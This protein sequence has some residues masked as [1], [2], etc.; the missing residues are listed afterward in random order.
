MATGRINKR[1]VDAIALPPVGKRAHLWDDELR[2]FGCMVTDKG[3]K[4]YLVQYRLGGRGAKTRRVTIGK[5]GSPWTPDTART[6]AREL[7][8]QIWR[9]VD[10]FEAG[11]EALQAAKAEKDA[12]ARADAVLAKLAFGAVADDYITKAKKKLRR[13]SE[14]E[15]IINRDLRP[16]FG[17]TPLPSLTAET[18]NDQ[19]AAIAE[20]S[21]SAALKAYV[22][23]RAIIAFAHEKHRKLYPLSASPLPEVVRPEAGGQRERHLDDNEVRLFWEASRVL[24]WPFGPIYNPAPDRHAAA[25]DRGRRMVGDKNG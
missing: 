1:A 24:G 3:A 9:K 17:D 18:I 5:H 20:R 11:R 25:R 4:S 13:A 10:P 15:Q 2:G 14:Q 6:R 7:L 23:L 16:A 12:K 22:A 19:L 21:A 8:E